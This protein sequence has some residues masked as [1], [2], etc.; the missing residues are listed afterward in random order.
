MIVETTNA[1]YVIKLLQQ[2]KM[3][4][5]DAE[6]LRLK[7]GIVASEL[8]DPDSLLAIEKYFRLVGLAVADKQAPLDLGFRVGENTQVREHG[9]LGY[10]ILNSI[11]LRQCID[12][13]IKYLPLTGPVLEVSLFD[14]GSHIGL[15]ASPVP[16]QWRINEVTLNYYTQEWLASLHSWGDLIGVKKGLFTEVRLSY[17]ANSNERLYSRHLGCHVLFDQTHTEALFPKTLLAVKFLDASGTLGEI[18]TAQCNKLLEGLE[19]RH[20]FAAEVYQK[21]SH[22][23]YVPGMADMA[24]ILYTSIRTL[25]RRLEKENTTYQQVVID[26]RMAMARQYLRETELP[27]NE[28]ADLVGYSNPANFFRTFHRHMSTTPQNYRRKSREVVGL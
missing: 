22:L 19:Q 8:D 16:A 12:R 10:A 27:I 26:F 3:L 9:V 7:A 24:R 28:I 11:D 25:R 6:A 4:G 21:L 23:P 13:Y 18:C 2:L 5:V 20:G 1:V 17:S 15:R 14:T